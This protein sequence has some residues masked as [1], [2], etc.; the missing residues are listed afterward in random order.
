M[1]TLAVDGQV[2]GRGGDNGLEV[3]LKGAAVFGLGLAQLGDLHDL[4]LKAVAPLRRE[5]VVFD[6]R[7]IDLSGAADRPEERGQ[8]GI[9]AGAGLAAQQ[10]GVVDL[11]A[12]VLHLVRQ[13]VQ[14]MLALKVNRHH[15]LGVTQP[16]AHVTGHRRRASV[17]P[18]VAVD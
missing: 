17:A 7:T 4:A 9:L 2:L 3:I 15:A 12:G 18:A 13:H 14:K 5:V 16:L 10:Y 11:V 1:Q 6:D 8:Q